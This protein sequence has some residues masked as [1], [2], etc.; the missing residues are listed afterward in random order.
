[1]EKSVLYVPKVVKRVMDHWILI[2]NLV[3]MDIVNF[4]KI[5][6]IQFNEIINYKFCTKEVAWMLVPKDFP[7]KNMNAFPVMRNVLVVKEDGI[8]RVHR[9]IMENSYFK[10]YVTFIA[11]EVPLKMKLTINV[12]LVTSPV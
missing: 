11:P 2:V 9:A 1:M 4:L 3:M 7:K 10:E 6:E 5:Q 8:T 12:S